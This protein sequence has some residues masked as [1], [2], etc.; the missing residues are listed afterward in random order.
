MPVGMSLRN[1]EVT[2]VSRGTVGAGSARAWVSAVNSAPLV[3]T[4]SA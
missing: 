4:V 3:S 1:D 2:A